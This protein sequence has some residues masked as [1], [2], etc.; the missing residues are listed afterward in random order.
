MVYLKLFIGYFGP[1]GYFSQMMKRILSYLFPIKVRAY[2]SEINGSLEITY[3]NGQKVLDTSNSNFSYGALQRVL[4]KGL[5]QLRFDQKVESILL[6]GLGG[7]SVIKTIREDFGSSAHITAVE[8][9]PGI[10]FIARQEFGI[11]EDEGLDIVRADA[12]EFMENNNKTFDLIIVDLFIGDTVPPVFTSSGFLFNLARGMRAKGRLLFNT[13]ISSMDGQG[14]DS[15]IAELR[16]NGL[17]VEVMKG[18]NGTNT[19]I[20]GRKSN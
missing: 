7:G 17:A 15:I 9:D 18:V 1:F 13:M 10:I 19:L 2:Q 16:R 3:L 12:R 5:K 4:F 14:S 6:L 11:E 8:L 20:L